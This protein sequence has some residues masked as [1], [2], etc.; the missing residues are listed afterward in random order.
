[1]YR[2]TCE[3]EGSLRKE[4][5]FQNNILPTIGTW[6]SYVTASQ[7]LVMF[8]GAAEYPNRHP[9][10]ENVFE[11]P[12]AITVLSDIPGKEMMLGASPS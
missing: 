3:I 1:M 7:A 2:V 9:V 8:N 4:Y 6:E 12:S 11:K 10:M 5:T